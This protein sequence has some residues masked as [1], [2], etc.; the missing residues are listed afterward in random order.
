MGR[1]TTVSARQIFDSRGNPTVEAEILTENGRFRGAVPSGASTGTN[2]AKELRDGGARYM[3]KGVSRAVDNIRNVIGPAIQGKDPVCQATIDKAMMDLDGTDD[4]SRLGANAILAVSIAVCRAGAAAKEVPLYKHIGDLAGNAQFVLPMPC[5]NVIN[6]GVHS[7]NYLAPQEFMIV[8]VGAL[9]FKE[10]MEMGSE[11]YH[12]LKRLI[13]AKYGLNAANVG[14]EGGFS[15]P[16]SNFED[17][18]D[19][20]VSAIKDAGYTDRVKI[21][22]DPASS[23]FFRDGLYDLN[24]KDPARVGK[25]LLSAE[26]LAE[27]YTKL[28]LTYPIMLLEDPFEEDSFCE[29]TKFTSLVDCQVVGDDLLCTNPARIKH[30]IRQKSCTTLLLKV[31]QIGTISESIEAVQ[32]AKEAKWRILASHRSGETEDCFLA[33]IAVGLACGQIKSGALARSERLSKYN[34]LLRI[35]EELGTAAVFAGL[36]GRLV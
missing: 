36:Q 31:N 27:L 35:E 15:P 1:I 22:V 7:G 11:T 12:H 25:D 29:F 10:A 2:E 20:L 6:G 32:L 24:F 14:D 5:F 26:A 9:S 34:Q 33:D 21:G 3:G 28:L 17:A 30:A 23:E 8:P 16:L 19:L 4:K 18:L 13:Q